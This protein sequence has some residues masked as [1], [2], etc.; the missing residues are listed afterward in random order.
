MGITMTQLRELFY[1]KLPERLFYGL[2]REV[3]VGK[4]VQIIIDENSEYEKIDLE[5]KLEEQMNAHSA[6]RNKGYRVSDVIQASSENSTSLQMIDVFMGIIVFLF[7]AQYKNISAGEDSIS[8]LVKSDL[9]YRLLIHNN[10]LEKFHKKITLYKWE[11]EDD[12]IKKVN[13]SEFTG[14]FLIYKTQYDIQEM[15]K[16]EK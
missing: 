11:G 5:R 15:K 4:Q 3:D 14:E 13:F 16:L 9:I 10:N 6:Y 2:T 1:V 8:K 12:Q 7:E